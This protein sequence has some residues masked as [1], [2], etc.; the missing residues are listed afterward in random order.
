MILRRQ[1]K[2]GEV[3]YMVRLRGPDG[4]EFAKTFRTKRE[5]SRYEA[6]QR[7]ALAAGS[8]VDPAAGKV[9][10]G[11][12]ADDWLR[13]AGLEWRSRTAEKHRM[14]I[15]VHWR[16]RFGRQPVKSITTNGVQRAINELSTTHRP[17][18]VRTYYGT[19]RTCLRFAVDREIIPRS[20]CRSIKLP[21]LGADEKVVVSVAD[22]HRLADAVGPRWRT[23]V[24]L[25]GV[26]GLRFGEVGALRLRDV[27]LQA[28]EVSV[29]QTL[30]EIGGRVS[31]G[32]PKSRASIRTIACPP[33]LVG[34][35]ATHIG[36]RGIVQPD[37]LLF[38]NRVG[39]P[40]KR[41]PF[42]THV[43]APAVREVG[44]DGLTFHGLRHSAA[45]QWVASGVNLRTVQ[46]WLGHADPHLVLRLYAHASDTAGRQA[47]EV[48][49]DSFWGDR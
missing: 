2:S 22:L 5:A 45:T 25:A 16:P 13:T 11:D 7:T 33:P 31:F 35:L 9:S 47:A 1:T 39:A 27:D 48:I 3:R 6:A 30:V 12:W 14:A 28:G 42:R 10:F 26:I 20:P 23:F 40:V 38:V 32:P 15:D 21:A 44:L 18:S 19:L 49:A 24:Y 41:S 8:W 43:F 4:R 37:D 17:A 46:A 29:A 36:H 34:E